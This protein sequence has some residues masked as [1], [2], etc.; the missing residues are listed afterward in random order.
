MKT[1]ILSPILWAILI[2]LVSPQCTIETDPCE[3]WITGA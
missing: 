1:K 3:G 2:I